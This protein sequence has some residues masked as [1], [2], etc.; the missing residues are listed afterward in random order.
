ML[1]KTVVE[2]TKLFGIEKD[3]IE[4]L[5]DL[6]KGMELLKQEHEDFVIRYTNYLNHMD[7]IY[8]KIIEILENK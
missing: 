5:D 6:R 3:L 2:E 1:N 4:E 7:K 8:A